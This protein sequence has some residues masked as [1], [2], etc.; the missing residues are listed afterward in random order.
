MNINGRNHVLLLQINL[1]FSIRHL[2]LYLLYTS[3]KKIF[4]GTL[5]VGI[6]HWRMYWS[7]EER[8]L[9]FRTVKKHQDDFSDWRGENLSKPSSDLGLKQLDIAHW[10]KIQ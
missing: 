9:A 6:L 7:Q 4:P 5:A 2:A 1:L 10:R 8:I 3:G